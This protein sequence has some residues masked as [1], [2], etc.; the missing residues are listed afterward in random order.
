M[1]YSIELSGTARKDLAHWKNSGNQAILK[2]IVRLLRSVKQSPFEG[3][4]KPEPLKHQLAGYWSRRITRE[5][6]LVYTVRGQ[7]VYVIA[8]RYHYDP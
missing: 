6:R 1:T 2:R 4:G 7:T 5:H 8:L 3:I